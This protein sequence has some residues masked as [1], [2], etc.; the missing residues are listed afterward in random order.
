MAQQ[1]TIVRASFGRFGEDAITRAQEDELVDH[2]LDDLAAI[3][4]FDGRA[5]GV[6]EIY[7]Q[8]WFGGLP[9]YDHTHTETVRRAEAELADA[10][11]IAATGAWAGGVGVPAVIAHAR[12]TARDLARQL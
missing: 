1:G 4:G 11:R 9:R 3:T 6:E 5:A 7:T 2:A 10:D 12:K 8:R